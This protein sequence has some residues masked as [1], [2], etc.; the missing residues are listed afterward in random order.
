[1]A[2]FVQKGFFFPGPDNPRTQAWD[3]IEREHREATCTFSWQ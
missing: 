1:V 2:K 3:D